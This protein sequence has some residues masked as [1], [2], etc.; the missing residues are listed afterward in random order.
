MAGICAYIR[1]AMVLLLSAACV[2]C[3]LTTGDA[4][5]NIYTK[6]QA[7]GKPIDEKRT[8]ETTP[9]SH[10]E[11]PEKTP[12]VVASESREKPEMHT[13]Q[14]K[15]GADLI[16]PVISESRSDAAKKKGQT[17]SAPL[18]E[19]EEVR[20]AAIELAKDMTST[21]KIKLCLS[22]AENEW[23]AIF[24]D[25]IGNL[26]DIKQ[27]IWNR[28]SASFSPFLV[29]KRIPKSRLSAHLSAHNQFKKCQVIDNPAWKQQGL[30]TGEPKHKPEQ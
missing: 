8:V 27:Y 3:M 2:G 13:H 11:T 1:G 6:N 23:W 22:E 14:A 10:K 25:D 17:S 26:I 20:H 30:G 18:T 9:P 19:E 16:K 29:L 21:Q 5:K 24:Y 28:D 15:T 4:L 7:T 12:T